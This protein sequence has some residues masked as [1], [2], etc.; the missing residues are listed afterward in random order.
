M[1]A[2][3]VDAHAD[4]VWLRHGAAD[5]RVEAAQVGVPAGSSVALVA[6]I[7]KWQGDTTALFARMVEHGASLRGGAA[8]YEHTDQQGAV[9]IEAASDQVS[10]LDLGL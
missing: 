10:T 4:E 9:D 1:S 3:T 8:A 6:A 7:T 5:G 2:A